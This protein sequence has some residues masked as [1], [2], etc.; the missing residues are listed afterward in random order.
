M[1]NEKRGRALKVAAL[2]III[3]AA[4]I[5]IA[6][7]SLYL[8][9][10]ARIDFKADEEMFDASIH[11]NSTAF[12]ADLYKDDEEY[13]PVEIETAGSLKKQFYSLDEISDYIKDGFIGVED[14]LFYTH[15]GVDFKRTFYA[16]ANL[17]FKRQKT[18]G[19]STIT[20]QVIKN[21]SGDN[22]VTLTRKISEIIRAL[23]IEQKYSKDEIFE[24]YLNIIPMGDNIYGVGLA[25]RAYF[26]KEP[27]ELSPAEA[28]TLIGITNAPTAYNPYTNT[29]MCKAKRNTVLSVMR[30]T[31]VITE[32]E[33][34]SSLSQPLSVIPRDLRSDRYDSWFTETV[35]ADITQDFAEKYGISEGVASLRLLGG[36]YSVYTTMDIRAQK[37]LEDVFSNKNNFPDDVNRGLEYSMVITDAKT[38]DISAIVGRVGEKRAN[39]ILNHATVAHTPASTLKPLALYA[40]LID[41]GKISWSSIFDDVPVSFSESDDGWTAYPRNSPAVYDGLTTVS[42]AIK[43]SKNTVAVRLYN[44]RGGESVYNDL[45]NRYGISTLVR[46][47]KSESGTLTDIAPSPLGLGQLCDGIHLRKMVECY[48]A[49]PANGVLSKARSYI[50]VIN[51][52]GEQVLSNSSEKKRIY[53]ESTAKIMNQLLMQ[54]VSDGTAKSISL[55]DK[56]NTAGKTGTAGGSYE[57]MFIGY[58]P[59]YVGG[60]W[61]GYDGERKAVLSNAHLGIWDK[62]MTA[63]HEEII[64]EGGTEQFS[65]DGLL[66]RAYCM[67]SGELYSDNCIL[68]PRGSRLAYGY[69]TKDNMPQTL[70]QRHIICPYDTLSKGVSFGYLQGEDIALVSLLD[71][72][73][74][75]FPTEIYVTDAEFVYRDIKSVAEIDYG[76]DLPYFY[77]LLPEGEYAGITN[78]K[79]QF[80]APCKA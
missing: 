13:T 72:P 46:S 51:S 20:Q 17:I 26:G 9:A 35:I 16:A 12:Y 52:S 38:G 40:P 44:M 39:R 42:D 79:R 53:K 55:K 11:W 15:R 68:D 67:D 30:D 65:T 74:R 23:S 73:D 2:I 64:S 28:A 5:L 80:N 61:C 29:D 50:S 14:R 77:A 32:S 54:V 18:F 4:I 69:F 63:L 19:A 78:R 33:Y 60:I 41:E 36:G 21:I 70:C 47:R 49:F 62:V 6:L 76:S 57:K 31:G 71:I 27:S 58:T 1:K 37:I 34:L 45:N 7:L 48:G 3:L 25:S 59:Y 66:Y 24:V 22:E 10:R 75:K 56:I 43:K 8:Y